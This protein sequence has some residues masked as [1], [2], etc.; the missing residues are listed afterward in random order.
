MRSLKCANLFL[1]GIIIYCSR[2][3]SS[4]LIIKS[5]VTFIP[6]V[7]IILLFL[8][9]RIGV[10][11]KA[12][13]AFSHVV[14]I[15][16]FMYAVVGFE[17]LKKEYFDFGIIYHEALDKPIP[18]KIDFLIR[19]DYLF[20]SVKLYIPCTSLQDFFSMGITCLRFSRTFW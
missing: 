17:H 4:I 16:H 1:I 5:F 20:K 15:I 19:D 13:N 9:H 12:A 10:K 2:S 7:R 8:T 14:T 6:S 3:L 11:N 18:T